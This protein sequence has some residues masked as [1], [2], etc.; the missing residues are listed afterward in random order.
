MLVLARG[1]PD[2]LSGLLKTGR[3]QIHQFFFSWAAFSVHSLTCLV[4]AGVYVQFGLQCWGLSTERLTLFHK[5]TPAPSCIHPLGVWTEE[6]C[7]DSWTEE[8]AP[9]WGTVRVR[10]SPSC[11]CICLASVT[12][13]LLLWL[14]AAAICKCCVRRT[15]QAVSCS[16]VSTDSISSRMLFLPSVLCIPTLLQGW[17]EVSSPPGS[18]PCLPSPSL[19]IA[20]QLP[21]LRIH[22]PFWHLPQTS[23]HWTE[24]FK[25]RHHSFCSL[26]H[27]SLPVYSIFAWWILINWMNDCSKTL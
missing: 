22:S 20:G 5:I 21:P 9:S 14:R 19:L 4:W 16:H 15:H 27:C 11:L 18:H 3:D 7:H 10:S 25:S 8:A 26:I 23:A 17:T 6:N 2:G 13:H 1:A 12:C 24:L